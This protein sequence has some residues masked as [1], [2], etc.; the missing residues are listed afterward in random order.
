MDLAYNAILIVIDIWL[1]RVTRPLAAARV[2]IGAAGFALFALV[3]AVGVGRNSFG[4][5]RLLCY[6][7][8]VHACALGAFIA[9]RAWGSQRKLA[10]GAL[11]VALSL[12]TIGADAFCF[13]PWRLAI[14][15][16]RFTSP[17]APRA[18]TIV[19]LAD[20]QTDHVSSYEREAFEAA[21]HEKPD[22]VLFAG[23]YVQVGREAL[24]RERR[25]LRAAMLEAG[26]TAPLGVFAVRGNV[27]PSGWE[28]IFEGSPAVV[29][30]ETRHVDAGEVR[31]TG[32]RV[33]DS[34]DRS[35]RLPRADRFHIALGHSPDF[36]LGDV[37]ADLLVAGHTHGGQVRLPWV[38]P[39]L[40][41]SAIPRSW[42]A[43]ATS[44]PGGRWLVVSKGVG[45]ERGRAPRLRFL[46]P[47]EI[48][49]IHVDP[50]PAPEPRSP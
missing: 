44:L 14:S 34:F 47:P 20:V 23:D 26:L 35:L 38:G 40:T 25:A 11:G 1:V 37:Q 43:G 46:C 5:M 15:H 27:D 17:R 7:L 2:V 3:L 50:A 16:V 39:L 32:L 21:M 8:F 9:V 45:L 12:A 48:V 24:G 4:M 19:V 30:D 33:D 36:A 31:V 10:L 41:F 49:V 6:A 22:I 13:E 42:A 29:F 18:L 28:E